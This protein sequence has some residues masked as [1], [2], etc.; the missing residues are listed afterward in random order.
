MYSLARSSIAPNVRRPARF[1]TFAST[2]ALLSQSRTPSFARSASSFRL[3]DIRS[4]FIRRTNHK[5]SSFLSSM[6]SRDASTSA[7]SMTSASDT[8]ETGSASGTA[9]GNFDLVK[10]LALDHGHISLEKW[11]S[12]KTGL[13]VAHLNC[14]CPSPPPSALTALSV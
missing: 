11:T 10:R 9:Y 1:P 8:P 12:R 7:P 14:E 4:P 6:S 13:S 5:P 2:F 3:S